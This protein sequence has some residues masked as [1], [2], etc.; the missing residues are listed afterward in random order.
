MVSI[1]AS[2][3]EFTADQ[4]KRNL[5]VDP[6]MTRYLVE[7]DGTQIYTDGKRGLQLKSDTHWMNYSDPISAP[8][9]NSNDAKENLEYS[10]QFINQHGGWNGTYNYSRMSQSLITGPQTF[11]FRQYVNNFP[12]IGLAPNNFGYIKLVLQKGVV[13]AYERSLINID[14]DSIVKKEAFLPGG[15]T[16]DNLI[17]QYPKKLDIVDVFP[18]YQVVVNKGKKVDLVPKWAV[19]LKDGTNEFIY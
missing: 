3:S 4:L 2:Y 11:L 6:S 18:A 15:K 13:S 5:F 1:Q 12:L 19:E 8:V 14:N 7:R 16:L 9:G 10:I 17:Q